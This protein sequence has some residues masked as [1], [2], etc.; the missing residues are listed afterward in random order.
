MCQ[1]SCKY[2][3]TVLRNEF[4]NEN[5]CLEKEE[6]SPTL[7]KLIHLSSSAVAVAVEL[8]G[9]PPRYIFSAVRSV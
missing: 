4:L 3:I 6:I 9:R 2:C 7:L 8:W 5:M 1:V